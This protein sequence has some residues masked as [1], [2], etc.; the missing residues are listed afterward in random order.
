MTPTKEIVPG[1][2]LPES[3]MVVYAENQPQYIPLPMW[4]G[5]DDPE[6]RRVSRWRLTWRE[7]LSVLLGGSIWISILTFGKPLQPVLPEASCPL[8][9]SAMLDEEV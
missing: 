7:R 5:L 8:Q 6:G 2:K 4:K 1:F 9:G 3:E